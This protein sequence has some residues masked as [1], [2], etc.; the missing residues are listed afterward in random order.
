MA[1]FR[2]WLNL[3]YLNVWVPSMHPD[4][5]PITRF[6]G[7][8]STAVAPITSTASPPFSSPMKWNA[9]SPAA[10]I[11][12]PLPEKIDFQPDEYPNMFYHC[13]IIRSNFFDG[14]EKSAEA[15]WKMA[16]IGI[17][18]WIIRKPM[19]DDVYIRIT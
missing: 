18:L 17:P 1:S 19:W 5:F 16:E 8:T 4:A 7:T 13:S 6:G 9:T 11:K 10:P 12:Q 14:Q 2:D 15:I 3:S